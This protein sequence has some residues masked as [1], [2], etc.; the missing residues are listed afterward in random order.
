MPDKPTWC[1]RLEEVARE[2]RALPDE[3]VDRSTLQSLLGVG[4]RR[5][6]QILAPCSSRRIGANGLARRE[7]MIAHLNRLAAG[8]SAHYERQR[9]RRLAE[10]LE[11]LQRERAQAVMVEA[12]TAIINQQLEDLPE[13]VSITPGRITVDFGNAQEALEKLLALAMAAGNDLLRFERM[14]TGEK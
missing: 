3:W 5:A 6:Q 9:R 4:P 7:E 8:E 13:G 2:L 14:A 1:G 12:P 10:Q 11:T